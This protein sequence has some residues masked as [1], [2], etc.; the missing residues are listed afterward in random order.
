VTTHDAATD[1][2]D[3]HPDQAVRVEHWIRAQL[4]RAGFSDAE[5]T[6]VI[7]ADIDWRALVRLRER[8]CPCRLA[9]EIVR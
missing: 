2:C 8:G 7:A 9:I 4:I 6:V 5:V 1:E 3:P